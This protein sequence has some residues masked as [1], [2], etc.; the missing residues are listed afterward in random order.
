MMSRLAPLPAFL[1]CT[2]LVGGCEPSA[3][4]PTTSSPTASTPAP[5]TASPADMAA[6][7]SA[8]TW[9]WSAQRKGFDHAMRRLLTVERS[10]Q[11]DREVERPDFGPDA[12]HF[13]I[14]FSANNHGERED[15]GCKRN[16]LGGLDR[17]ATM[18][19]YMSTPEDPLAQKYWGD[20]LVK[21]G[22]ELALDA[23]DGFFKST[24]LAESSPERQKQ[25]L[26]DAEAVVE[27][28]N[29]SPPD[30]VNIGELDL[31]LGKEA[32]LGL[33]A[34]AR[35]PFI[36][37]NLRDAKTKEL[38]APGHRIVERGDQ[39]I[40]V[41]GLTKTRSQIKDY[42]A[43]RGV[44]VLEG[45][46][47]YM[48]EVKRLPEDVALVVLLTNDGV[49]RAQDM[50]RALRAQS[51][52]VDVMLVSNSNRLT[53]APEWVEGVPVLE[54]MSR[55][56]HIGRVDIWSD[57][58]GA[59]DYANDTPSVLESLESYRRMHGQYIQARVQSERTREQLASLQLKEGAE[60]KGGE[61]RQ[62]ALTR[63]L[64]AAEQ[65]VKLLS[66]ELATLVAGLE[67]EV[68]ERASGD[69]LEVHI[70]PL[71]IDIAQDARVRAVLDR[72]KKP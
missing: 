32:F 9:V 19:S 71:H 39:K 69:W 21:S 35:F 20:D 40:A 37:A 1:L 17:R 23:G 59:L 46:A 5:L 2:L 27:A 31:A 24:S 3:S 7:A 6:L 30:A 51:V 66:G 13:T 38:L 4:S 57:Q 47:A 64:E 60:L 12:A 44:E 41:I 53:R 58:K 26:V 61:A 54:P 34:R 43:Q 70:A 36:S 48:E 72:Y 28:L 10:A 18:A 15:C 62:L 55:G 45:K 63:Q 8:K 42:Y 56:K 29:V 11:R 16:P 67:R 14:L 49:G 22:H 50:A 65:R 33:K 25:A 68:P 52:R